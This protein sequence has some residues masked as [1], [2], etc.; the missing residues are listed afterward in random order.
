[1]TT[2]TL[3]HHIDY[4]AN[5]VGI[6]HVGFGADYIP[7]IT[8]TADGIQIPDGA[9]RFPDGGH[10]AAMGAKGVPTPAPYQIVA[11]LVDKMLEKGYSEDDCGKSP[12]GNMYRVMK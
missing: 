6:D 9:A 12:G 3:F 7:D 4:M 11:A 1:V 5:L 8:Y 2:D 10:S